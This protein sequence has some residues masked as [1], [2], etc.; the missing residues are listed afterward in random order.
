VPLFWASASGACLADGA[1]ITGGIEPAYTACLSAKT[2]CRSLL[3]TQFRI[4]YKPIFVRGF[5]VRLRLLR[6]YQMGLDDD[7]EDG[8]S[9][10]QQASKFDPPFDVI[11]VKLRFSAPDGR[12]HL[13]VRVGYAYQ[14][15]DPN[16]V[17]GYHTPYLSGDYYF[18]PPIPSGWG[19]LSRRWDVLFKISQD[20]YATATRLPED[21]N[22]FVSTYTMPLNSD[23]SSRMYTSYARELRFSGS[24]TV[25]TPSNRFDLGAT[26]NPTQWLELYGR[27]SVYG[28][29]GVPGTGKVVVGVDVTI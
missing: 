15:S 20:R 8:S 23:G 28:T 21:L 12:D 3:R 29:R 27:I 4:Q 24:N 9:E 18:G 5:S 2:S 25:L 19:G 16:A 22:Q 17:D 10:E 1:K 14:H 13:E 11:D 7:R 6:G 26:R